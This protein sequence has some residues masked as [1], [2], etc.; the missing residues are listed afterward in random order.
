MTVTDY[1]TTIRGYVQLGYKIL[2]LYG[3]VNGVCTCP[4]GSACKAAGKHPHWLV[5]RGVLSATNSDATLSEWFKLS[6]KGCFTLNWGIALGE[7]IFAIDVDPRNGGDATLD[8]FTKAGRAISSPMTATTGSGGLHF[9]FSSGKQIVKNGT[10]GTGIDIKG[11]SGYIVVEPSQHVSGGVYRWQDKIIPASELPLA[12]EWILSQ[13]TKAKASQAPLLDTEASTQP[14]GQ[15]L[16]SVGAMG[17]ALG[18]G[19][20]AVKCPWA[21]THSDDR[22]RGNDSS[23]CILPGKKDAIFKCLHG[24]CEAKSN[25]DVYSLYAEKST[26]R[27]LHYS[28]DKD[29]VSR[30]TKNVSNL[31]TLI[32]ML[33]GKRLFSDDAGRYITDN[34]SNT[35]R[36]ADKD[37]SIIRSEICDQFGLDFSIQDVRAYTKLEAD[38][39]TRNFLQEYL[40]TL[41]WDGIPRIDNWLH[42]YLGV[43]PSEYA[44]M[45][46]S[47]WLLAAVARAIEPGCEVQTVLI[48]EGPQGSGK[49]KTLRILG[50]QWFSDSPINFDGQPS[51]FMA[52]QSVWIYEISE[53]DKLTKF[54]FGH[55]KSYISQREDI[56]KKPYDAE[57]TF[58]KRSCVFA[59]SVDKTTYLPEDSGYRRWWPVKVGTINLPALERDRDQLWAE[60]VHRYESGDDWRLSSAL[61]YDLAS[62][63]QE[64]RAPTDP[65][66][67]QIQKFLDARGQDKV[68]IS[69]ILSQALLIEARNANIKDSVRVGKILHSLGW[70]K[71]RDRSNGVAKFYYTCKKAQSA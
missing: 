6:Q 68:T 28:V 39:H 52:L 40:H 21:D 67:D 48:L 69:D 24:H 10:L 59:A 65:W 15:L 30:L 54:Q 37:Y 18:E 38:S 50:G 31:K 44:T 35:R 41:K 61:Q 46:G 1:E 8:A 43:E 34:T 13:V 29:G 71:V 17:F 14:L 16:T 11:A 5:K 51:S 33:Y 36:L 63:E 27:S 60:A 7:G 4:S 19:R 47:K 23:T 26:G 58:A 53:L 20:Y 22:G 66:V 45:V 9:L 32:Q 25:G 62:P 2:P 56:Y 55:L 49:G 3:I 64:S 12:P 57:L 42:T 70:V